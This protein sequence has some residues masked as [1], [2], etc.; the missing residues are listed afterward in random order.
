MITII[1]DS[2]IEYKKYIAIKCFQM[3]FRNMKE[4]SVNSLQKMKGKI[5]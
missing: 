5:K 1:I 2:E 4:I 3:E